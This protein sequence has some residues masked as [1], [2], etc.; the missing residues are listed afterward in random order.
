MNSQGFRSQT[1]RRS[2][3]GLLLATTA[4]QAQIADR[5]EFGAVPPQAI[6]GTPFSVTVRARSSSGALV[7]NYQGTIRLFSFGA[8]P[9][10]P[11]ITEIDSAGETVELTNP[12]EAAVDLGNWELQVLTDYGG[13][14]GAP[15]AR[16]R[17]PPGTTLPPQGVM[18][19]MSLGT[20]PGAFPQFVSP[21]RFNSPSAYRLAR[22]FNA[23]GQ[24][25]D[26]VY[27]RPSAT[28]PSDALWRG[29]GLSSFPT[30]VTFQRVGDANHYRNVDWVTN[31]PSLGN[32]NANLRLPWNFSGRRLVAL[33]ESV[34]FTN[35]EWT[36]NLTLLAASAG[37]I[38]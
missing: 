38:I 19:W 22:L 29:N 21:K 13:V 1:L 31:S 18:T 27:A 16:L 26:E 36:G 30:N 14:S 15:N 3:W 10:S 28:A 8:T 35:G 24:R 12:G 33:P 11:L 6:A 25:V 9:A 17:I 32:V 20:P 4:S 34:T 37:R 23:T 2:I 7:M 5:F